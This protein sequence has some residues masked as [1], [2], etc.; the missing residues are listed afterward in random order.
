MNK[1][2]KLLKKSIESSGLSLSQ[3]CRLLESK[4]F[5]PGK[6]YL[7]KL[8]NGKLPPASD[9]MNKALASVLDI[10][11]VELQASAYVVKISPEVLERL[12]KIS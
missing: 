1:Y 7:S 10:D 9:T 6:S 5:K 2:T 12:K 3:I 8:Q 4:G 11:S